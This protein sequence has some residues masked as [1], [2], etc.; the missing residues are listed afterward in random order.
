MPGGDVVEQG[1][2]ALRGTARRAVVGVD[3]D[4]LLGAHGRGQAALRLRGGAPDRRSAARR[5]GAAL[6]GH[7]A[8]RWARARGSAR[9]AQRP[10][11]RRPRGRGRAPGSH[12]GARRS[13]HRGA[14]EAPAPSAGTGRPAPAAVTS[15]SPTPADAPAGS[16]VDGACGAR[17]LGGGWGSAASATPGETSPK[18]RLR[19]ACSCSS[20]QRAPQ[21]LATTTSRTRS[22]ESFST[23]IPPDDRGHHASS[24]PEQG[25]PV[26]SLNILLR[27]ER[28]SSRR[29]GG[30]R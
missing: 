9:R 25:T 6:P 15:D 11:G 1:S 22:D 27:S 8:R 2:Q 5:Y 19:S 28:K 23:C 16:V 4:D 20:V 17:A 18:R 24:V 30:T 7:R 21:P 26:R 12:R 3:L 13:I 29:S 10:P 14:P